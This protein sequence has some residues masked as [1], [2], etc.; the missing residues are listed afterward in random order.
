MWWLAPWRLYQAYS[1]DQLPPIL[2]NS[3]GIDE[4]QFLGAAGMPGITALMAIRELY[5]KP[6]R[7]Q[8][9]AEKRAEEELFCGK[10][11]LVTGA[12]GAVGSLAVQ[13]FRGLGMRV[14]GCAGSADKLATLRELGVSNCW[15]YRTEPDPVA[16]LARVAPSGVDVFFDNVGG[17][18]LD[19]ALKHMNRHGVV[20]ACGA[21]SEY[22]S[23]DTGG[24]HNWFY[25]TVNRLQVHG[26]IASDF[27]R[28]EG[29]VTA[30]VAELATKIASGELVAPQTTLSGRFEEGTLPRAFCGLFRG[31]NIGKM[32]VKIECDEE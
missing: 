15:N 12:A 16:A 24:L 28:V 2:D 3:A 8:A 26:F 9:A 25:I 10:T 22:D 7:A 19:A 14:V 21:I 27:N 5:E 31:D 13:L 30:A 23:A 11:A 18:I 4:S 1:G 6:Q 20:L 32:I 17:P 29:A